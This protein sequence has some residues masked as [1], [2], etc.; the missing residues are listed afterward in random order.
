MMSGL[1][2]HVMYAVLGA[3]AARHRKSPLTGVIHRHYASYLAGA[4][5]GCDVQTLPEA[6]CVDTGQEVGYGTV[7]LQ[8]S[9][10]TGGSVRPWTIEFA[11]SRYTARDIH[12]LFYGRAHLVFGWSQGE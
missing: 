10:L 12:R 3:K 1:I 4:Y 8:K 6:I 9:P 5:L 2:G 11:G 7:P